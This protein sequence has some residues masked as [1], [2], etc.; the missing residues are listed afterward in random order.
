MKGLIDLL[1]S[2]KRFLFKCL[3]ITISFYLLFT[4]LERNIYFA[5]ADKRH[6]CLPYRYWIIKKGN[7]TPHR[8]QY[9]AFRP[10]GTPYIPDGTEWIKMVSGLPG[11]RIEIKEMN[12]P[13]TRVVFVD[14]NPVELR[15]VKNVILHTDRESIVFPVYE[16]DT[17]GRPLPVIKPQVI[18]EGKL[19][20]S[21]PHIRSYDSRYWGLVDESWITGRAYPL[22]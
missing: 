22:Y 15:A 9:I 11:D 5:I 18:P 2:R 6:L 20:V 8:G 19:F 4:L 17:R 13:W 1:K 7:I 12:E 21:S 14:G 10:H 16:K 3:L